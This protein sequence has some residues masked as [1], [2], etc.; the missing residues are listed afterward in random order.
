MSCVPIW[1]ERILS[2]LT[3]Q[4]YNIRG[5]GRPAAG[6]AWLMAIYSLVSRARTPGVAARP[7]AGQGLGSGSRACSWR[8]AWATC[9]ACTP[10]PVHLSL[11]PPPATHLSLL[12][13]SRHL[14]QALSPAAQPGHHPRV[15]RRGHRWAP[16][17]TA[18]PPSPAAREDHPGLTQRPG[19]H[20]WGHHGPEKDKLLDTHHSFGPQL[21][22]S[23]FPGK[24]CPWNLALPGPAPQGAKATPPPPLDFPFLVC[25]NE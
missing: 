23:T 14:C 3:N 7:P 5:H 8:W 4:H 15:H 1:L 18:P 20:P 6:R 13:T 9:S 17:V 12:P 25:I 22:Q 21:L 19:L 2:V 10:E 11:R 24:S 16:A